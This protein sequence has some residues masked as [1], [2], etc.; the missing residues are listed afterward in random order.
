M[1][2]TLDRLPDV[3]NNSFPIVHGWWLIEMRVLIQSFPCAVAKL[4]VELAPV[5]LNT[6][7]HSVDQLF[8]TLLVF[9]V[10]ESPHLDVE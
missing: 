3:F 2:G 6:P 9:E 8:V 4:L 5:S 7:S 1:H 10:P